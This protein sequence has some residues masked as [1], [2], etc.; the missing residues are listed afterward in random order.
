MLS[1]CQNHNF[2]KKAVS[3]HELLRGT[4]NVSVIMED[5]HAGVARDMRCKNY[6]CGQV[7]INRCLFRGVGSDVC[8]SDEIV[9]AFVSDFVNHY[10]LYV[11]NFLY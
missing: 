9:K 5:P 3:H 4:G 10:S 1:N 7:Y 6:M 2:L 8:T 11:N